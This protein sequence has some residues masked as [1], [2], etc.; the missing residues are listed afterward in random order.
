MT[1]FVE[2]I[3]Q[4]QIK[5]IRNNNQDMVGGR[6]KKNCQQLQQTIKQQIST[7]TSN[8]TQRTNE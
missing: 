1:G 7:T 6:T 8:T 2:K 4:H 5:I 3:T